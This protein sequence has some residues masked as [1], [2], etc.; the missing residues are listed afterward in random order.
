MRHAASLQ[1]CARPWRQFRPM[2]PV[3]ISGS[4]CSCFCHWSSRCISACK[5]WRHGW[6]PW[7]PAVDDR[8]TG[9]CQLLQVARECATCCLPG[10]TSKTPARGHPSPSTFPS[11]IEGLSM[12]HVPS[13]TLLEHKPYTTGETMLRKHLLTE[14]PITS[15]PPANEKAIAAIATVLVTSEA[16]DHPID[17]A[18]DHH[19]GPGGSRRVADA[20]GEQRL[21]LAFDSPQVIRTISLE[22]EELEVSRTHV[23]HL[24][25]SCD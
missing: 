19:R 6:R 20:P 3:T 9:R 15:A 13:T 5:P 16:A 8:A 1:S 11:P 12:K 14:Q 23:L 18:F 22:V 4:H 2:T 24:S 25:V 7:S 17:C 10:R 21:I